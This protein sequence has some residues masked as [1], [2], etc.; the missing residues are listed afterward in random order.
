MRINMVQVVEGMDVYAT[1]LIDYPGVV[2]GMLFWL[3]VGVSYSIALSWISVQYSG[4]TILA[5]TLDL[6]HHLLHL[7]DFEILQ[8]TR[9]ALTVYGFP[10]TFRHS[11]TV[12]ESIFITCI[13]VSYTH[14]TLPTTPYV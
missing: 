8:N 2:V 5:A 6:P 1:D 11:I 9:G 14:L 12:F 7:E 3:L 13:A 10:V 4:L